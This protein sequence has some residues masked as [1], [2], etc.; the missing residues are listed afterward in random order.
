MKFQLIKVLDSL[1]GYIYIYIYIYI[2]SN[3]KIR[4]SESAVLLDL[5]TDDQLTSKI[6]RYYA[7]EP[8]SSFMH[9]ED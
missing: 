8:V 4:E 6:L 2:Y 1:L 3:K 7:I 9:W 5:T